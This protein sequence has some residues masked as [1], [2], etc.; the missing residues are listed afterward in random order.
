MIHRSAARRRC[1]WFFAF[2]AGWFLHIS[3]VAIVVVKW[4]SSGYHTFAL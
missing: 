3:V 2:R 1:I 4:K